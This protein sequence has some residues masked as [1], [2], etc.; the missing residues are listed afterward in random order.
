MQLPIFLAA[1]AA[2]AVSASPV[3]AP[4]EALTTTSSK[5]ET[6][7]YPDG[8]PKE[9]I[10]RTIEE[11]ELEKRQSNSG[12]YLCTDRNFGGYCVH[13]NS[14]WYQCGMC[15]LYFNFLGKKNFLGGGFVCVNVEVV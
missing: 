13:N 2:L 11:S 14:P 1:L 6:T 5:V 12:V 3:A 15:D 4:V 9:L 7:V 10:P 8:L